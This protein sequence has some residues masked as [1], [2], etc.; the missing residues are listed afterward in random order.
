[1]KSY[2]DDGAQSVPV[3]GNSG[4]QHAYCVSLHVRCS[5]LTLTC[6][7]LLFWLA[8]LR[9]IDGI[10]LLL[11][12]QVADSVFDRS[13]LE[14]KQAFMAAKKRRETESV[15]MTRAYRDKLA[16]KQPNTSYIVAVVRVRL[17]EGLLLQASRTPKID[18]LHN[19]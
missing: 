9:I 11:R 16:N 6:L 18:M 17:P 3:V 8:W 7:L 13:P 19:H 2:L 4:S 12:L 5:L 14:L 15:L 1:M 10:V